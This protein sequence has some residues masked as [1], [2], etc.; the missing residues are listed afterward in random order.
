MS[1]DNHIRIRNLSDD[2]DTARR[3]GQQQFPP[4]PSPSNAIID[5]RAGEGAARKLDDGGKEGCVRIV[6]TYLLS[7]VS[8]G[9]AIEHDG[10]GTIIAT[11]SSIINNNRNRGKS[12]IQ[13]ETELLHLYEVASFSPYFLLVQPLAITVS[14]P[15]ESLTLLR[16]A[17][18]QS[19][20]IDLIAT[21]ISLE[22]SMF[23]IRRW[24][25]ISAMA[26]RSFP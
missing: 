24:S 4:R 11:E 14:L 26:T 22:I 17:S 7:V 1:A 12:K 23:F 8:E 10:D 9:G 19:S 6:P 3:G 18:S 13:I 16:W 2:D 5:A 20:L 21:F 15:R 25:S